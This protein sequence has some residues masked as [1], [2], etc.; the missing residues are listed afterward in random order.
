MSKK[1]IKLQKIQFEKV[2]SKIE[3]KLKFCNTIKKVIKRN[4]YKQM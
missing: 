1:Y 3:V 4:F 2:S